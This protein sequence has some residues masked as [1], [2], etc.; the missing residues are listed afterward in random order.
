[1]WFLNYFFA[2]FLEILTPG[3]L[4]I[5]KFLQKQPV[6]IFRATVHVM[7]LTGFFEVPSIWKIPRISGF[8]ASLPF[9]AYLC[10]KRLK[11]STLRLNTKKNSNDR[12]GI[13]QIKW[14]LY[15]QHVCFCNPCARAELHQQERARKLCSATL[16]VSRTMICKTFVWL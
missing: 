16:S 15:Q 10:Y 3:F 5:G 11:P 13:E 9:V 4:E 6:S 1:M 14:S 8:F 12:A 7:H 2:K